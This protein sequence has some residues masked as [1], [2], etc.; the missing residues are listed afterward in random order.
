M[1]EESM[2][3]HH[4]GGAVLCVHSV[5]TAAPFRRQGVGSAVLRAYLDHVR[6]VPGVAEVKLL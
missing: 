4:E 3:E 6:S 2:S 1:S 5:V